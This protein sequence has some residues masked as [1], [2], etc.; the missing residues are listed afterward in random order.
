MNLFERS[1]DA[2]ENVYLKGLNGFENEAMRV[3]RNLATRLETDEQTGESMMEHLAIFLPSY[4]KR[5][6]EISADFEEIPLLGKLDGFNPRNRKI[7]EYKTGKK[8]TQAMADR[9]GQLTFYAILVW[10][11]Y[12]KLP[13]EIDLHWI[14]TEVVNNR[15]VLTNEV[16]TFHTQ[17][18]LADIILFR[19]RMKRVWE[20]IISLS[21]QYEFL[22]D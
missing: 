18:T 8:W 4:P 9:S 14:K 19:G 2:Y 13:P 15:I 16:K 11:K 10:L 7:G 17:R 21:K 1:R 22:R 5:E 6:F 3:G 12:G 20:G